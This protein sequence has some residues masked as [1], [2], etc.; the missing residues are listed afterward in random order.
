MENLLKEAQNFQ[1]KDLGEGSLN[2]ALELCSNPFENL[3]IKEK[4]KDIVTNENQLV[5]N[6]THEIFTEKV[7][8]QLDEVS[9]LLKP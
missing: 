2:E 3:Q 7:S 6:N 1:S 5:L 8:S 4:E 9:E